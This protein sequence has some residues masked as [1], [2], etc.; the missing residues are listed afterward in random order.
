MVAHHPESEGGRGDR[1]MRTGVLALV[2]LAASVV[3]GLAW[4][5]QV[6]LM[7]DDGSYAYRT[8]NWISDHGLPPF[9]AG[10]ERGEQAMG[11]PVLFFW[12]WAV[13]ISLFGNSLLTARILPTIATTLVLAG[14]WKL[15]SSFSRD[16]LVGMMAV[17]GLLASPVF[18][19]QMFRPLPDMAFTAA[20]V[21]SLYHCS[22]N[23]FLPALLFACLA[24]A[25]KEQG[26]LLAGAL[27]LC[28][29]LTT[30]RFRPRMLLWLSPLLVLAMTFLSNLLANGYICYASHF[31][32]NTQTISPPPNWFRYW[33]GYF[34]GNILG[35]DYRWIPVSVALALVLAEGRARLTLPVIAALLAPAL[36]HGGHTAVYTVLIGTLYLWAIRVRR[37]LPRKITAVSVMLPVLTV[38]FL[39]GLVPFTHGSNHDLM[40]YVLAVYPPLMVLLASR[41]L[42]AGWG[43]ALPVWGIFLLASL[44]GAG[45]V[46]PEVWQSE[47]SPLGLVMAVEY[48]GAIEASDNPFTVREGVLEDPA[49]GFVDTPRGFR[50]G[51]QGQLI[52][53]CPLELEGLPDGY[54]LTGDTLYSW[55]HEDLYVV[56]L[57][58]VPAY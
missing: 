25:L 38:L 34:G 23:R 48:R 55:K 28:D 47:D 26:I 21:W 43:T 10:T 49:L 58:M 3:L 1:F 40:R 2:C 20:V 39:V 44:S 35:A 46:G 13:C 52:V 51:A 19:T 11:H 12:L 53:S 36:F 41:I 8:A 17:L 54:R 18:I 14:T 57:Q 30:R 7:G 29:L 24:A 16:R 56:S 9:A 33:L 42:S 27:F 4:F 32:L 50:E 22:R 31:S 6:P 37:R 15:A 5:W 45:H